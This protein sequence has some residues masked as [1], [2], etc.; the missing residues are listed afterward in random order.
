[1]IIMMKWISFLYSSH[2]QSTLSFLTLDVSSLRRT[3][4]GMLQ[5]GLVVCCFKVHVD[6]SLFG[7]ADFVYTRCWKRKFRPHLESPHMMMHRIAC[8]CHYHLV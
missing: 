3:L 8:R 1:V 5:T 2:L 4:H 7:A 6:F